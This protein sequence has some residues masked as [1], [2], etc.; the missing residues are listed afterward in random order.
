[1]K[2]VLLVLA[3]IFIL[4]PVLIAAGCYGFICYQFKDT[5]MPGIF[6][7]GV[8]ASDMTP[9]QVNEQLR[10]RTECPEFVITDKEGQDY[11]FSLE[12]IRYEQDFLVQ[13]EDLHQ[14]QSVVKFVQWFLGEDMSYEEYELEPVA[15]FDREILQAYLDT[16]SC[17][18][19]NSDPKDKIVE[20]RKDSG[21]YY[22]YD[23]TK[24]LF[25]HEKAEQ[26]I[27]QN[28]SDRVFE[29][30]LYE[31]G[32]YIEVE[33]TNKM[34]ATIDLWE[35]LS[36]FLE[37]QIT[38]EFSTG[39]GVNTEVIDSAVISEF[40]AVDEKGEFL[41]DESG[42]FYLNE[43]KIKEH[44][45]SLAEKYNTVNKPRRFHAT[46]GEYVTVDT[47]TYGCKLDEQA[48]LEYLLEVIGRGE[49]QTRQPAYKQLSY[50]G[51]W[52]TDDIGDTYIE[53][54]MTNQMMYYYKNGKQIIDTPVVTGNVS[55]GNGTPQ[56]VCF[57][58]FKQRNRVL[59]GE[60]YE[61]PVSYWMAVYG[62][63]GI[64]DANWRG[65]FGGTIYRR[66]G[67]HGCINTPTAAVS[68]LYDMVEEGTPVII[69]Y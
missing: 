27:E 1:M 19:D 18:R 17:L 31:Q 60:D 5:F 6:I 34:K 15:T 12:E 47:G 53:I 14:K 45:S 58:Y 49:A 37:S 26:V 50:T 44:I 25:S 66:N 35:D 20:I 10:S 54:D 68:R 59:R 30:D 43:E 51:L 67:S 24:G 3:S 38:Y 52:G 11:S 4:L 56:K 13:L 21:G 9:A 63:I 39:T 8:Y 69:F 7:N 62:N 40:I 33:H 41:F 55:A 23:E 16:I 61:T 48:E 64:H 36:R 32:C 57:V 42:S 46:R 28:L 65:K 22:L 2:K 29:V